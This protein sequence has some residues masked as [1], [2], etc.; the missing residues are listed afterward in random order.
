MQKGAIKELV[1][2]MGTMQSVSFLKPLDIDEIKQAAKEAAGHIDAVYLH[3]SAGRYGQVYDSYHLT[4]DKDGRI[5]APDDFLDFTVKRNHTWKR[6][7]RAIGI[8]VAAAFDAKA[9]SGLNMDM[10]SNPVTENQIEAMAMVMA[11]L[12]RFAYIPISN[13]ITHCEAAIEDGYGPFSGDEDTRWDLWY[14]PDSAEDYMLRPGGAV[15]RGKA[16]WYVDN[17]K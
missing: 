12:N 4:I 15:L 9:N 7:G 13:M 16:R 11:V 10:G 14:L 6:N 1:I 3:W 8:A 17:M 5:Y 2:Y